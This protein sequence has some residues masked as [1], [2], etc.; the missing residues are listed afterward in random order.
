MP[1]MR[2]IT[3]AMGQARGDVTPAKLTRKGVKN[4][5]AIAGAMVVTLCISTSGKCN[6]PAFSSVDA[7]IT[8]SSAEVV[9]RSFEAIVLSSIYESDSNDYP[10]RPGVVTSPKQPTPW[11][12]FNLPF[13][14]KERVGD[15]PNPVRGLRPLHPQFLRGSLFLHWA[16]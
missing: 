13:G 4:K 9:A 6:A 5:A 3:K 2:V 12:I 16:M 1:S 11:C 8:L 10:V 15:T 7:T 14:E